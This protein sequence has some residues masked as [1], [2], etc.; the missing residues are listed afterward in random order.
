MY[1][2]LYALRQFRNFHGRAR[3]KEFWH[4]YLINI[5]I[6]LIL[7][8]LDGLFGTINPVNGAGMI[9]A[10]Y[11]LII[12]VPSIALFVRR[13]HDTG[14]SGW[15]LLLLFIPVIGFFTSLYFALKDSQPYENEYG[16]NRKHLSW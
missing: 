9:S 11:A 15:W 14:R 3:R 12:I 13:I 6:G 1:H 8:L 16:P 10:I 7:S 2:Y 4:F 5:V